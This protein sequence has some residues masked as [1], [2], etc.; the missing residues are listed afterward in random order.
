VKRTFSSEKRTSGFGSTRST[1][2][3]HAREF[4][5]PRT[6]WR[7]N[8]SLWWDNT[9]S[10]KGNFSKRLPA[11]CSCGSRVVFLFFRRRVAIAAFW[12]ASICQGP[13]LEATPAV[14]PQDDSHGPFRSRLPS[15]IRRMERRS[16]RMRPNPGPAALARHRPGDCDLGANVAGGRRV[17]IGARGEVTAKG[18]DPNEIAS[19][20]FA[21]KEVPRL[22]CAY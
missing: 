10:F 11:N 13:S 6:R 22:L 21:R 18:A 7:A 5:R 20:A 16:G 9:L 19:R 15:P 3:H 12:G 14:H 17:M 1:R 4:E 2:G 8:D